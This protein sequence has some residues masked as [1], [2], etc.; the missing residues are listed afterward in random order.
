MILVGEELQ[1]G[2]ARVYG[3]YVFGGSSHQMF[4]NEDVSPALRHFFP[5]HTPTS[6]PGVPPHLPADVE[7][8]VGGARECLCSS[9]SLLP[10]KF[11]EKLY[12]C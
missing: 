10:A 12:I 4:D 2:Y 9:G 8:S 6:P 1:T 11:A 7:G 5:L 3:I